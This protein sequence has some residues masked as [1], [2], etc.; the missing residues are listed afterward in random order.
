M[1]RARPPQVMKRAV[2]VVSWTVLAALTWGC[3]KKAD[4]AVLRPMGEPTPILAGPPEYVGTKVCVECHEAQYEK[5]LDSHHDLAMQ[6]ATEEA[7]LGD[8][9]T[10]T[11]S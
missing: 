9:A 6:R 3:S 8:F 7:V 1:I 2:V 10:A 4:E 11:H 5:W